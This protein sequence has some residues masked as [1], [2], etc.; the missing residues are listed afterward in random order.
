M[1]EFEPLL[2]PLGLLSGMLLVGTLGYLLVEGY[3]LLEAVYMTVTTLT[4]VGYGEVRPLSPAGRVFTIGLILLGVAGALVVLTDMVRFVYE[5]RFGQALWRQRMQRRVGELREHFIVCGYGRVGRHIADDLGRAGV[6]LVVVDSDP[7][8]LRLAAERGLPLVE[9]DATDDAVLCAAGVERARGLVAA[10]GA[11]PDNIS[12]TLSARALNPRLV[13][14]ARANADQAIPKLERAGANRVVSP[15]A[16]GG[17]RMAMLA[18]RPLTVEFVDAVFHGQAELLLEEVELGSDSH[19]V[20]RT[21]EELQSRLAPG[22]SVLALR[23]EV[24][25]LPRPAGDTVFRAGDELVV[26]GSAVELRALEALA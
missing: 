10:V 6:P 12:L 20:G 5:G 25:I 14:V 21:V 9:G 13:I 1:R 22:V 18:L 26:M 2:R 11:D 19:L 3:T 15:H 7:I 17:R 24:A 8:G 4:T 16:I 23:R